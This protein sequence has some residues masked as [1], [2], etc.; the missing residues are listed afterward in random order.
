MNS[1]KNTLEFY[2]KRKLESFNKGDKHLEKLIKKLNT[3]NIEFEKISK[4]PDSKL[5]DNQIKK[6][7]KLKKNIKDMQR[8]VDE[9]KKKSKVGTYLISTMPML[10][11]YYNKEI[12][13]D[14]I[15]DQDQTIIDYLANKNKNKTNNLQ[16]FVETTK[17]FNKK[18]IFEQYLSKINE[19]HGNITVDYVKNYTYCFKCKQEK[20]MNYAESTYVCDG[21][22]DSSHI[23]MDMEKSAYKEQ[24]VDITTL[25]YK[26]Y[27]HFSEWL[28][29]FQ[30]LET[31]S[32]PDSVYDKIKDEIKKQK[33]KDLSK[34]NN[35]KMRRILK[36]I[37][38]NKYY[39]HIPHIIN[40]INDIPPPKLRKELDEKLRLMFKK[41]QEPFA[42]FCPEERKNFLSYS[43]VIRKFLE[44][45][46][47]NEY[48][49]YFP[50]LKS[51]EKLYQQDMIWKQITKS[52]GWQFNRSI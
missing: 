43:Y 49:S 16:S 19:K 25:S 30:A 14:E 28:S 3:M 10:T 26:R 38:Q 12:N 8:K 20:I 13:E 33:I 48:I 9:I 44:I 45:L 35:A 36:K 39:E 21:C 27:N 41:I 52:L 15:S 22:G 40:K 50:L 17:T 46:D 1:D 6:K 37:G 31:T 51:R 47:E 11:A 7:Y 5:K 42:K 32:I 23:H 4:T 18:N 24:L 29:Q 34:M 2:H